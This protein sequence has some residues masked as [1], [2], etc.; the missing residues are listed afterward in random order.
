MR[1]RLVLVVLISSS[2]LVGV[3]AGP[4]DTASAA[5]LPLVAHH[6]R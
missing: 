1:Q 5:P 3:A 6:V 2:W 4:A